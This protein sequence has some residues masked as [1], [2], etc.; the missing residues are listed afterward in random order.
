MRLNCPI[1]VVID[2]N[3]F[4]L[5]NQK[6]LFCEVLLIYFGVLESEDNSSLFGHSLK[7]FRD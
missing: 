4:A 6:G 2:V 7:K 1:G 3:W 5:G